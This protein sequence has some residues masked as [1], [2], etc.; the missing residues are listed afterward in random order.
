MCYNTKGTL[1]M[2]LSKTG[3]VPLTT[4]GLEKMRSDLGFAG[5]NARM[6]YQPDRSKASDPKWLLT[7]L[8]ELIRTATQIATFK[9]G[10]K[11]KTT[12][13]H[14][15]PPKVLS[16]K[17]ELASDCCCMQEPMLNTADATQ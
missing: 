9:A 11:R 3:D 1:E 7:Q 5:A 12:H 16:D 17:F 4:L 8:P 15:F 13:Q 14:L 6:L 10:D 2:K